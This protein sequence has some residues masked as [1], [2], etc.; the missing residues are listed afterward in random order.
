MAGQGRSGRGEVV[1]WCKRP[2][3]PPRE[4]MS[5]L[6]PEG[7]ILVNQAKKRERRRENFPGKGTSTIKNC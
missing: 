2:R 5:M 6:R 7:G 4:G 3:V 1:T